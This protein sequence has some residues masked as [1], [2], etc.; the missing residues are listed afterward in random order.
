[1]NERS[2][3]FTKEADKVFQRSTLLGSF[4]ET[5]IIITKQSSGRNG[6]QVVTTFLSFHFSSKKICFRSFDERLT[7]E[8]RKQRVQS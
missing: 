8:T 5:A 6:G 3:N 4:N 7:T 1:M 2:M